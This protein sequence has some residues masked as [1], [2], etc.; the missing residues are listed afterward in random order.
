MK[1]RVLIVALFCVAWT[2]VSSLSLIHTPLQGGLD[3]ATTALALLLALVAGDLVNR[4]GVPS[5]T[6]YVAAGIVL[7]PI[8][9]LLGGALLW[10]LVALQEAA[11]AL[12]AF[13]AGTQL[14]LKGGFRITRTAFSTALLSA[15]VTFGLTLAAVLGLGPLY[16][17]FGTSLQLDG[18]SALVLALLMLGT[19]PTVVG[20]V[21]ARA[22]APG[23]VAALGLTTALCRCALVLIGLVLLGNAEPEALKV[24]G[25]LWVTLSGALLLASVIRLVGPRLN[26]RATLMLW[27]LLSLCPSAVSATG[28]DPVLT[29]ALAGV[30]TRH[31]TPAERRAHVDT[32]VADLMPP[33]GLVLFTLLGATFTLPSLS[34][35]PL[36]AVLL[37]GRS[38]SLWLSTRLATR[39]SHGPEVFQRS[40]WLLLLPQGSFTL[41]VLARQR[42]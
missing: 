9:G 24:T 20:W 4:L 22:K 11:L 35:L 27:V 12:L 1:R 5:I 3:L 6:G 17:L 23:E 25:S 28:G 31:W 37:A 7:G 40:G 42:C 10:D 13:G 29:L 2:A 34:T 18:Q 15:I 38:V 16:A 14:D 36:I 32:G 33:A 26:E 41:G 21:V 8:S 30:L 39:W 19:S